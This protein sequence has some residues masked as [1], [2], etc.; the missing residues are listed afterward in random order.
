MGEGGT[1][2]E[3]RRCESEVVWRSSGVEGGSGGGLGVARVIG[4]IGG[5]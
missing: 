5:A 2:R 1:G 3:V 4:V